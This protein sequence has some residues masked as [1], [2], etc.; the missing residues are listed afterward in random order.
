MTV[1]LGSRGPIQYKLGG[2]RFDVLGALRKRQTAG[3]PLRTDIDSL[4]R[5]PSLGCSRYSRSARVEWSD[6]R[7]R[8]PVLPPLK[9]PCCAAASGAPRSKH[10]VPLAVDWVLYTQRRVH[11]WPRS[12][13]LFSVDVPR[14]LLW[15]TDMKLGQGR[16]IG[17]KRSHDR[18]YAYSKKRCLPGFF[19]STGSILS[20]SST[21]SP[22]D[23]GSE[24]LPRQTTHPVSAHPVGMP[25]VGACSA[26]P[27]SRMTANLK[28]YGRRSRSHCS[29]LG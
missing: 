13:G 1:S 6:G 5:F 17:F 3:M 29:G 21:V 2:W 18:R 19:A 8:R 4:Q 15:Q 9:V 11:P 16:Q 12:S 20:I 26:R 28:K 10:V 24:R 25:R 23:R 27:F 14:R 22:D 7:W